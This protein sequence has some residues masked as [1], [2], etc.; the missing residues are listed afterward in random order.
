[1]QFCTNGPEVPDRPLQAHEDGRV[2]LFC[3]AGIS[4]P[5]GLPGFSGLVDRLYER[6]RPDPDPEQRKAIQANRFDT[7]IGL[8]ENGV[9]GGRETVRRELARI[10]TP[11]P[12]AKRGNATHEALL[13]LGRDRDNCTRIVTTNFDRLFET[14]IA[15]SHPDVGSFRAPSPPAKNRWN[16]LVYLHG[17]LPEGTS[18]TGLDDLV[19]SSGDFGR[20][21]LTEGWAARFVAELLRSYTVCFIGYSI[22]D[23]V[24]RYMIDATVLSEAPSEMFAFG[25]YAEG[26]EHSRADEWKAKN[27]TPILYRQDL[28]HR[29]LHETLHEWAE[30]YGHGVSGKE[31]IVVKYAG[32]HPSSSTP[33]D[34]F[35]GRMLWALSD[36][37]GSPAKRFAALDPVPSLDWLGP[38]SEDRFDQTHLERFG[39]RPH[40]RDSEALPFSLLRRPAPHTHAPW[41]VLAKRSAAGGGLDEVMVGLAQWLVRHLDDPKLLLWLASEEGTLHPWF[42]D[43]VELRLEKEEIR[44]AMRKLWNLMIV[45]RMRKPSFIGGIY[46][47]NDRFSLEGLTT[48][49]RLH[50]R[51]ILTPRILLSDRLPGFEQERIV[52]DQENPANLVASEIVLS[53]DSVWS[54]LSDVLRENERWLQALPGLLEDFSAL[55]RDAMDLMRELGT[56]DDKN[57][58]SFVHQPSIGDHPRNQRFHDWTVLIELTRDAW[59]ETAAIAPERARRLAESWSAASYPV[60]RRLAFFAAARGNVIPPRQAMDWLLSDGCR[61]LWSEETRREAMRLLV[62]LAPRLK[63][64]AM[65]GLE[66]AVMAG[67]PRA[68]YRDDIASER[69]SRIVDEKVWLRLAKMETAGG[70]LRPRA[71]RLLDRLSKKHPEWRLAEDERDEFPFWVGEVGHGKPWSLPPSPRRRRDLVEWLREHPRND[72]WHDDDWSGRCRDNFPATA[73]ALCALAREGEWP[74]DR[75]REALYAWSEGNSL[76]QSW[77]YLAPLLANASGEDLLSCSYGLTRWLGSVAGVADGD[78]PLF[79]PLCER[80]LVLDSGD[81]PDIG[82]DEPATQAINRPVGHMTEAL[83]D[84]WFRRKPEDGQG[85]P[86]ELSP[87]FTGLCD[88]QIR[89]FR[90]GRV[91]LASR[92]VALFRIDRDWT[93]QNLL[94]IFDWQHCEAEARAAWEGFFL[95]PRLYPPLMEIIGKPFLDMASRY[96][97]L[98]RHAAHN[99]AAL[100]TFEALDRNCAFTEA[101]LRAATA[102]L[103]DGALVQC[104]H[105]LKRALDGAGE[106]RAEY[107]RNRVRPYLQSVW[108]QS[109]DRKTKAVSASLGS[110]CIA[111]NEMFPEALEE[112]QHWLQPPQNH[113]RLVF[114][115][116]RSDICGKFPAE[117]LDFL[118]RV[119]GDSLPPGSGSYLAKCLEGIA[120][121]SPDLRNDRRFRRLNELASL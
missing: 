72:S 106:Q 108:P 89:R 1:M 42:S 71:R 3:G 16:G 107:W 116:Q 60:F 10:L 65:A 7:A 101:E 75:W 96:A 58:H 109:S 63:A 98:G 44:P 52:E 73:C 35:I 31:S 110:V 111:A 76:R 83:L 2:V 90:H 70:T 117:A 49:L 11:E 4:Y 93:E 113:D 30:I 17:L 47:W 57:D 39:I 9:V 88:M 78:D 19:V 22:D 94:P 43:F 119:V 77:R 102:S 68:M 118:N 15:E 41:M 92:V 28:Q 34:N 79:L 69:W 121:E 24:L 82:L 61:W 114:E 37:S 46:R 56:A 12:M 8:L 81:D 20:A 29:P 38:L 25:S 84:W 55:L 23:P 45:G 36:P 40:P 67:P 112:L 33:Q 5:G 64:N 105:A 74:G 66:R 13:T 97:R 91:L 26:E 62:A 54:G 32:L 51:D 100:L 48:G 103:P 85:L 87:V 21:Y 115:L 120:S 53:S 18:T 86:A 104:A 99:Y 80:V 59:L 6:L 95:S 14:A 50:L 27:V